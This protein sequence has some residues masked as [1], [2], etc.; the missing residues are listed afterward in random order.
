MFFYTEKIGHLIQDQNRLRRFAAFEVCVVMFSAV[1]AVWGDR[2][3]FASLAI[4]LL[5]MSVCAHQ[6]GAYELGVLQWTLAVPIAGVWLVKPLIPA[7]WIHGAWLVRFVLSC[8]G[9]FAWATIQNA[10]LHGFMGRRLQEAGLDERLVP[11]CLGVFFGI[12]HLPNP[13]LTPL[14]FCGGSAGSYAFLQMERKS[15]YWL[16]IVHTAIV[17]IV[18]YALPNAWSHRLVIG[19]GYW[20][21]R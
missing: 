21:A 12:M 5:V 19:P 17:M 20:S 15:V 10:A 2:N 9:Y 1:F 6:D 8:V 3:V 18:L 7:A 16:A 14:A 11:F 4:I 13:I